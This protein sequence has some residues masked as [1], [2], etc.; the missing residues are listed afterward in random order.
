[1]CPQFFQQFL[2]HTFSS[3]VHKPQQ[4]CSYNICL[5]FLFSSIFFDTKRKWLFF[6]RAVSGLKVLVSLCAE[7]ISQGSSAL[8]G[9][10]TW[11]VVMGRAPGAALDQPSCFV[12]LNC[13]CQP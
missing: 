4:C 10:V 13:P 11:A 5:N 3:S 9:A 2:S 7:M 12:L 1:M 6:L 8:P